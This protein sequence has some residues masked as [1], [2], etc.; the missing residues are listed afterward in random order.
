M[1]LPPSTQEF[2]LE[3][4]LPVA[5]YPS[6]PTEPPRQRL[7]EPLGWK[8]HLLVL[9]GLF[10]AAA[11]SFSNSYHTGE[12]MPLDNRYIIEEYYKTLLNKD[13]SINIEGWDQVKRFFMYDY[14]WPKGISGLYRPITSLSYW[15]DYVYFTGKAPKLDFDGNPMKDAYGRPIPD[16][17]WNKM[18]WHDYALSP[19]SL[20]TNS[21]H[22]IN[23]LLHWINAVLIYFVSLGLIRKFWP[24]AL[25]ALLFVTHPI[26]TE[27][28]TNVIGRADIF[29]AMSTFGGLLFY[30][31][32]TCDTGVRRIPWL[33]GLSL[34]CLV[35]FFAKESAVAI[36]AIVPLY[37][38]AYKADFK[39]P[40]WWKSFVKELMFWGFMLPPLIIMLGVRAWIFA[41]STPA[42][43]PF[44]DNPIRGIWQVKELNLPSFEAELATHP[45]TGLS[46]VE[47]KMT[48]VKIMGKLIYLLCFPRTLCCDYSFDQIPNFTFSFEHPWED[49][50]A[51]VS[52]F[53]LL[54]MLALAIWLYRQGQRA[55]FFYIIFFFLAALPTSNFI[56]TIGSVMAE[57]F[58]Y[59]PLMGFTGCVV[60]GAYAAG[61]WAWEK[62][63]IAADANA[64]AYTTIVTEALIVL[65]LIYGIRAY[66]RNPVWHND[67]TLWRD[68]IQTSPKSFRCYQSLA[69]ALY[70]RD[71]KNDNHTIDEIINIDEQALPILGKLPA[72]LNSSRLYL[73]IGMYYMVKGE[74]AC[75]HDA[76]GNSI[77]TAEGARCFSRAV[78]ILNQGVHI[79]RSFNEVNRAKQIRRGD[80]ADSIQDVGLAPVYDTLGLAYWRLRRYD[81]AYKSYQYSRQLD[82]ITSEPY[83][84]M[85][86]MEAEQGNQKESIIY[87]LQAIVL[88]RDESIYWT[89]LSQLYHMLGDA[90]R[91]AVMM[92]GGQARLNVQTN[93]TAKEHMMLALRDLIRVARRSYRFNLA[94]D[95][96]TSAVMRY[97]YPRELFDPLFR[98]PIETVTPTGI[99]PDLI[100]PMPGTTPQ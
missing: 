96:W 15:L 29:A 89:V 33:I 92:E 6:P 76:N 85:A 77:L 10:L 63:K 43:E 68:A 18:S 47:C 46:K 31:R 3:P 28:V 97:E 48:S 78:D 50:V 49:F 27:S 69:F 82:P 83:Y 23:L 58:M 71:P 25:V 51:I 39:A 57:R 35:G 79:D 16:S 73:H 64:P 20:R 41:N 8:R 56:V 21:Y 11:G 19:G 88:N 84:R 4:A 36:G 70:E 66:A 53:F 80:P 24:A 60:L 1:S 61:K 55:G 45:L 95:V 72:H 5:E 75:E 59:L 22:T 81:E 94:E 13:P 42:E 17:E 14:W 34:V 74:T 54:G 12:N 65:G 44:L 9:L 100:R 38:F 90:G 52:L 26:T 93:S 87:L 91:D 32:S 30:M 98:E 2:S 67:I 37:W 7:W 86:L 40:A 99:R 62:L